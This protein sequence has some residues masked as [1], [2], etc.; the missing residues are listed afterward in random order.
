MKLIKF[1]LATV[2]GLVALLLLVPTIIFGILHYW[3]LTPEYLTSTAQNA[4]KEYTYIDFDCKKIE[5]DYLN[6]WPY[7]SLR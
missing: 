7:I 4:V 1:L 3:I 5:L 2:T 6:T